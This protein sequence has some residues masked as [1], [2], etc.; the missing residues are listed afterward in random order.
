MLDVLNWTQN[1]SNR[2]ACQNIF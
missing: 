1:N 2:T